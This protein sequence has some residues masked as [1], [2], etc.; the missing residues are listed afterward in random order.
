MSIHPL[1]TSV[2]TKREIQAK[3]DRCVERQWQ[4]IEWLDGLIADARESGSEVI[5]IGLA[6][7]QS[8]RQQINDSIQANS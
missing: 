1:I 4:L 8:K 5:V 2:P 7:A 3:A 6:V